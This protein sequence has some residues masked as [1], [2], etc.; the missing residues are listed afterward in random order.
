[1]SK[2]MGGFASFWILFVG[3][4]LIFTA[5]PVIGCLTLAVIGAPWVYITLTDRV[6]DAHEETA[7]LRDVLEQIAEEGYGATKELARKTLGWDAVQ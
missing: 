5:G 4:A 3:L 2:F 6:R 7:R 1:M